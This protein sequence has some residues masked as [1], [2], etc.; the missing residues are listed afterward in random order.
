MKVKE[1]ILA[2]IE[3]NLSKNLN[4]TIDLKSNFS[5]P[6]GGIM[7]VNL[8]KVSEDYYHFNDSSNFTNDSP[9]S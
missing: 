5:Y 8:Y 1:R 3:F 6:N 2:Q 9:T 7:S 4:I